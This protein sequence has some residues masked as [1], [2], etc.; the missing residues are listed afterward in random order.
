M[1]SKL[2]SILRYFW[3][4]CCKIYQN[5]NTFFINLIKRK[6]WLIYE[7]LFFYI[8]LIRSFLVMKLHLFELKLNANY[9]H[10]QIREVGEKLS[11]IGYKHA[12][13]L[14]HTMTFKSSNFYC[15]SLSLYLEKVL[16]SHKP[17]RFSLSSFP[18]LWKLGPNSFIVKNKRI[19][20]EDKLFP[21]IASTESLW[22]NFRLICL[23]LTSNAYSWK[24]HTKGKSEAS[25]WHACS[26]SVGSVHTLV[27]VE[28]SYESE[29]LTAQ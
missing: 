18:S 2:R 7:S 21:I 26:S 15:F 10:S 27:L 8:Q 25:K 12:S 3:L 5:K 6:T 23:C 17:C 4:L 20:W 29:I 14:A 16:L 13:V 19:E 22:Q 11:Q 28:Y 9:K 1:K 24:K